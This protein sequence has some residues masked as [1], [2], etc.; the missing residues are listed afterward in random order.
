[1]LK[2]NY[3][4]NVI[5]IDGIMDLWDTIKSRVM[6]FKKVNAYLKLKYFRQEWLLLGVGVGA[7]QYHTFTI[8]TVM[9]PI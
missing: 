8:H 1:M 9:H 7:G 4:E 5:S 3:T 2:T 6:P